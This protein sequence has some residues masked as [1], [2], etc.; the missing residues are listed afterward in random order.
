MNMCN[1]TFQVLRL[2]TTFIFNKCLEIKIV[3]IIVVVKSLMGFAWNNVHP[4]SQTVAQHCISIGPMYR[5]I[6]CFWRRDVKWSPA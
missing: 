6:W 4:V 3:T 1:I 2:S 5:V